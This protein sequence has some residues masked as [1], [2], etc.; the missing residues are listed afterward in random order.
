MSEH[1]GSKDSGEAYWSLALDALL[2]SLGASRAGLSAEQAR[3]RLER[4]GPNT[5]AAREDKGA[6]RAFLEQFRNP[7]SWLL[8]FA[9][10]V[11]SIA[12][13]WTDA[14]VIVSI[15]LLGATIGFLHERRA[16]SAVAALRDRVAVRVTVL[17][18]GG[19]VE[20][21]THEVV[22][23]DVVVLA[24]GS[25]VPADGVVI[26][27]KDLFVSESVLTGES[28]AV[29]KRAGISAV[30]A[31]L[32]DRS[33]VLFAGT[34]VRSGTARMLVVRVGRATE[35]G[36]IAERLAL[37]S[38][39]TDFDRGLR[40][41]GALLTRVM[42]VLVLFTTSANI[43]GHKPAIDALL[44]AIALAVGLAPEMLPAIV[45]VNLGRG[46]KVMAERGV[47][48]RKLS[49]IE[50]FGAMNVL[51]TDKTGTLTEG[52]VT[53]TRAF[54]ADER[55]SDRVLE[56][57]W[58]NASLQSTHGNPLDDAIIERGAALSSAGV[59]KLDEA[60]F[61]FVRKRASV[62]IERDGAAA[63]L[64]K[65]ALSAVL[66]VCDQVRIGEGAVA[67]DDAWRTRIQA[68]AEELGQQGTRVLAVASRALAL[69][70]SYG[71]EDEA[72]MVFE[73]LLALRDPPKSGAREAIAQLA[74]L[75][76]QVKMISGDAR[77]VAE[78]VAR[79]VG[80]DVQG[81]ITGAQIAALRD[82]A[83]W[84]SAERTT[85]FAEVDP[86]QKERIILALRKMGHVVGY[87][88]DG[89]N[90]APALHAADV[91]IS[92][93][94]ATDVA[95]EAAEFVLLERDL[96][97]LREGVIAG[98]S[99][100]ANTLKYLQTTES[101]N[102]GN[103]LSMAVAAAFLPFLPLLATQVLL[104]NFLSDIP[105]MAIAGDSVDPEQLERPLRWDIAAIRRFMIVFGLVSSAFDLLT[106][107]LLMHVCASN[108]ALFRTGWFVESLLTEVAVALVVR[109]QRPF[110]KSRP[111]PWLLRLSLLVALCAV[112]IPY[113]PLGALVSLVPLPPS[114]LALVLAITAGYVAT[115]EVAKRFIAARARAA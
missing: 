69:R 16:S 97:V 10:A 25:L 48:V 6:A 114:I 78:H 51:C 40:R 87:M 42:F 67:L 64:T 85:V 70:S 26:E 4:D 38:P 59:R 74:S 107:A 61:D 56:L 108:A 75:G 33:N 100:F 84:H 62:A 92:V 30:D 15:L 105:A 104:N 39:E 44:F 8:L 49:A 113:T 24:G 81:V 73:G 93:D 89:I 95:R 91:G 13:E 65:G 45:A 106:F 22:A 80:L 47:I 68:I 53:V 32:S 110:Y 11:S 101:A 20:V 72:A 17:R 115:V 60:P 77:V 35:Y 76:V 2:A 79:E 86:N 34:S 18:A 28:N 66:S 50:N 1:T 88:G 58:L 63:L 21:P 98:R 27:S 103:M 90:D 43:L 19:L 71:R 3:E 46:A 9:V 7:L 31:I 12:R 5:I 82:E 54:T 111:A 52:K 55:E 96:A 37:D 14:T 23:G 29:E 94:G 102:F 36:R 112:A 109:T 83:L 57:A 99:T 41:F